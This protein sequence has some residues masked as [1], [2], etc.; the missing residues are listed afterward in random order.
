MF[1]FTVSHVYAG[2]GT[3]TVTLSLA[4]EAG[5]TVQTFVVM[6]SEVAAA[7]Y[8]TSLPLVTK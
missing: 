4:D 5:E 1:E 8:L 6:V 2:A 3:Y 7:G